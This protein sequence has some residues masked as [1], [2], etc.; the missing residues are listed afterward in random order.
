MQRLSRRRGCVGDRVDR[1]AH[2][3]RL[4]ERVHVV[5]GGF[6]RE[7]R[8][9]LAVGTVRRDIDLQRPRGRVCRDVEREPFAQRRR[10]R[11]LSVVLDPAAHGLGRGLRLPV[12]PAEEERWAAGI[13]AVEL[14]EPAKR[15]RGGRVDVREVADRGAVRLPFVG[16]E[17]RAR[18]VARVPP[19]GPVLASGCAQVDG[20]LVGRASARILN[21]VARERPEACGTVR[22]GQAIGEFGRV[23]RRGVRRGRGDERRARARPDRVRELR[24]AGPVRRRGDRSEVGLTPAVRVAARAVEQLDPDR[25]ARC[26]LERPVARRGPAQ[27]RCVGDRRRDDVVVGAGVDVD[28][29]AAAVADA[30]AVD[31][32]RDDPLARAARDLDPVA[33]VVVDRV[34]RPDRDVPGHRERAHAVAVSEARVA[35]TIRADEVAC[36]GRSSRRTGDVDT[37]VSG[38]T[39]HH[40]AASGVCVLWR[41]GAVADHRARA[42]LHA[43]ARVAVRV[44]LRRRHRGRSSSRR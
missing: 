12:A 41:D 5:P 38:R 8:G 14:A 30:V 33:E 39:D 17:R 7:G 22:R 19:D 44:Q 20:I 32:V 34:P 40:V 27:R 35:S 13:A 2:V 6:I 43:D 23:G 25:L 11:L 21:D 37:D 3:D 1:R 29:L 15:H 16:S 24:L 31:R 9:Q 28:P 4:G 36:E 42:V 26:A 10:P 18:A